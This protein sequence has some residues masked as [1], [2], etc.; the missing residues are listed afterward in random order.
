[1]VRG[2]GRQDANW[3]GGAGGTNLYL[4][5]RVGHRGVEEQ[6]ESERIAGKTGNGQTAGRRSVRGG[7]VFFSLRVELGRV[8]AN[9]GLGYSAGYWP[10][11]ADPPHHGHRHSGRASV[12]LDEMVTTRKQRNPDGF[13]A[14]F[15]HGADFA[16]WRRT[17]ATG[18]GDKG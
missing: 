8:Q 2:P 11:T 5:G 10:I 4:L 13:G 18:A 15:A 14:D 6:K 9:A 16:P 1:M 3:Q 12:P 7:L 17:M